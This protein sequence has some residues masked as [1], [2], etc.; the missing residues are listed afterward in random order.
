MFEF[1]P[2]ASMEW[3]HTTRQPPGPPGGDL[4]ADDP[5]RHAQPAQH[6]PL[7]E[8]VRRMIQRVVCRSRRAA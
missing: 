7:G 4:I 1:S 2:I 6:S 8:L 5:E 3:L